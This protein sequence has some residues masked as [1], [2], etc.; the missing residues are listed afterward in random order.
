MAS[1][2]LISYKEVEAIFSACPLEGAT[3]KKKAIYINE[4]RRIKY[5]T[6]L[7]SPPLA[8][9][10]PISFSSSCS[11]ATI[12]C[13]K[14]WSM[15]EALSTSNSEASR[16][17]GGHSRNCLGNDQSSSLITSI[18]VTWERDTLSGHNFTS[19]SCGPLQHH[20]GV[21]C[22][23]CRV[24]HNAILRRPWIHMMKVVLSTYHQLV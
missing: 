18:W 16:Q 8:P 9:S 17:D 4:A 15:D 24:P 22:G 11:S 23:G 6:V 12:E 13:L 1:H 20:H 19:S 10:K 7:T 14:S 2:A 5:P 21:L 3:S